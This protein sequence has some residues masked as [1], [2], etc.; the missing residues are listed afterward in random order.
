MGQFNRKAFLT[1]AIGLLAAGVAQAAQINVGNPNVGIDDPINNEV[2]DQN[3]VI[4][5]SQTWTSNNTYNLRDQIFVAPGATLTIEAGT[6]I[7]SKGTTGGSGSLAITAGAKIFILGTAEKPVIMTSWEDVATW[8]GSVVT[9]DGVPIAG[10]PGYPAGLVNTVTTY[11]DARTGTWREAANEWGNLTIM[12]NGLISASEKGSGDA[13]PVV[14]GRPNTAVPD[15]L[16]KF[17]MEGLTVPVGNTFDQY[18]GNND[19][20]DSGSI[21]YLSLRYGGR[22]VG[23]TNELNGLSL[24]GLGRETDIDHIEIMNN[25]DDGIEIWGGT[26]NLRYVSIWNI[27][28]DSFDVDQGWRGKAQFVLI[29]QGYSNRGSQGSGT[30]DNAIETDGAENSDA[31]PVTTAV[32]ANV[33]VIGQPISGDHATAWRDNARVQYHNCI[34]MDLG[35]R[36]VGADNVDGDGADGYGV[37]HLSFAATWTTSHTVRPAFNA[38]SPTPAI[39]AFNHPE[40]LYQA[41]TEGN[42]AGIYDSVT[43]NNNN[44]LAY[45]EALAR[46]VFDPAN[47]NIQQAATRPI[48]NIA[49]AEPD[50][51]NGSLTMV[52]VTTLDPRAAA[53]AVTSA[54]TPP[55]DGFF[56]QVNFR[57]AFSKDVNWLLGWTA[58]DAFGFHKNPAGTANQTNPAA[59]DVTQQVLLT[60]TNFTSVNGITYVIQSS[61]DGLLWKDEAIVVGDGG[62]K[63]VASF[64]NPVVPNKIYRVVPQ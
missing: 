2:L 46:G 56:T 64:V 63:S 28:D 49:R 36:L 54:G 21:S 50:N 43:F 20:D 11:G 9:R 34:F 62:P 47:N 26:L 17:F 59:P 8:T 37:G 25:V 19:N 30:G 61:T 58:S 4:R 24:G 13:I 16:N 35:E 45:T 27:G 55:N 10:N 7:A 23:L 6:I 44:G 18:G 14:N 22:V 5:V 38:F 57:G 15:G 33:T 32:F 53:D 48:V 29:V 42:L 40:T 51:V 12:G 60:T 31:Q 1:A 39:G 41:Q 52:R 3:D